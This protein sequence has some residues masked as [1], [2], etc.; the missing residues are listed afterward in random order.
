LA[1]SHDIKS[2]SLG[3]HS[4]SDSK[5]VLLAQN[6][7]GADIH[8]HPLESGPRV[9]KGVGRDIYWLGRS[10]MRTTYILQ[11]HGFGGTIKAGL[12]VG[13]GLC[14]SRLITALIGR[15]GKI[16]LL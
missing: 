6:Q 4:K 10:L 11:E 2:T 13:V 15:F 7:T 1:Q 9:D 16:R 12:L 8:Y 3:A 5:S 14:C